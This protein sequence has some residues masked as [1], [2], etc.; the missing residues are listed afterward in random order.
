[1]SKKPPN[2]PGAAGSD[3]KLLVTCPDCGADIAIDRHTGAVVYHRSQVVKKTPE[4]DFDSL[5]AGIDDA[6]N[7]AQDVFQR[8]VKALEDRDRLM[9]EKF[10]EAMRRAEEDDD[11]TP[12]VR[13]WDLD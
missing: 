8:E 6:K 9:E 11:D 12:P 13:P 3:D 1:M 2:T 5:L 10:R 7:R 4:K